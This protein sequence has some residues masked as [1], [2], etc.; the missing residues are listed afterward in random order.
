MSEGQL[1]EMERR[2]YLE[3]IAVL[4]ESEKDLAQALLYE[5]RSFASFKGNDHFCLQERYD[6]LLK[7]YKLLKEQGD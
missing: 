3:K 7:D 6:S 5:Q 4:E 2:L 1:S